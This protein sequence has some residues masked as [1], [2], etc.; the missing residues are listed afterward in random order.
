VIQESEIGIRLAPD[1]E[2]SYASLTG[3]N[4]SLGRLTQAE[5]VLK[6][7]SDRNFKNPLFL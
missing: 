4:I 5:S 2:F 7:A 1:N 3:V 6:R